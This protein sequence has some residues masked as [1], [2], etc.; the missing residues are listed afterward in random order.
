MKKRKKSEKPVPL[1]MECYKFY[2]LII[3]ALKLESGVFGYHII[4][5]GLFKPFDYAIYNIRARN[6]QNAEKYSSL[7]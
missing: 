6:I 2:L 5:K 3:L 4:S 1:G 7:D